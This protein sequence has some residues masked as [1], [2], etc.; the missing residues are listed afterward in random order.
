MC[1]RALRAYAAPPGGRGDHYT[2]DRGTL[3]F[4]VRTPL[5]KTP[6]PLNL[7]IAGFSD[8]AKNP[9]L[10]FGSAPGNPPLN[11]LFVEGARVRPPLNPRI[12]QTQPKRTRTP[13]PLSPPISRIIGI[14]LRIAVYHPSGSPPRACRWCNFGVPP[15]PLIPSR[16]CPEFVCE[17]VLWGCKMLVGFG[18]RSAPRIL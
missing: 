2:R 16:G 13:P 4:G 6:P 12:P 11:I 8:P 14:L 1:T 10:E 9:P 5:R 7:P 18:A 3:L 15:P 17:D